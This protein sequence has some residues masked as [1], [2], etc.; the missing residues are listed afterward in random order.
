MSRATL[1]ERLWS[2]SQDDPV[3]LQ[4][5]QGAWRGRL[6]VQDALWWHAHPL[7]PTPTGTPDPA[8]A[9]RPLQTA[10]YARPAA[11][12]HDAD[13][14]PGEAGR[15]PEERLRSLLEERAEHARVLEELLDGFADWT[16]GDAPVRAGAAHA[17]RYAGD[18]PSPDRVSPV[19]DSDPRPPRWR[20][21]LV[22]VAGA[23]LG[24]VATLGVQALSPQPVTRDTPLTSTDI[25][26]SS[27]PPGFAQA[28]DDPLSAIGTGPGEA[29]QIFAEPPVY[30]DRTL[31]PVGSDIV[32]ESVRQVNS[33]H[34]YET[35]AAMTFQGHYC[36]IIRGRADRVSSSGCSRRSEITASGLRVDTTLRTLPD[37]PEFTG[38]IEVRV[39]WQPDGLFETDVAETEGR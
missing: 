33:W 15:A 35:F 12:A 28:T 8:T 38:F 34:S 6:D 21:V 37:D 31:P 30:I 36:L 10:V 22:L 29:F 17:A 3:L 13:G 16:A 19:V 23:A 20:P 7:T 11:D 5:L 32:P 2:A 14:E 1:A 25:K 26:Q 24:I 18:R 27:P 39:T 9:L 4:Q